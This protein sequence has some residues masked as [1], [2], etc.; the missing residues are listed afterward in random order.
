[1]NAAELKEYLGSEP[2]REDWRLLA[3]ELG[4]EL[5]RAERQRVAETRAALG[6]WSESQGW[7]Q[8]YRAALLDMLEGLDTALAEQE[9][10]EAA[11]SLA[12]SRGWRRLLP[13]L[14]ARS[15]KPSELAT[16]CDMDLA[17]V[18][19]LLSE[20]REAGLAETAPGLDAR[21]RPHRL[22]LRGQRLWTR[23]EAQE[24]PRSRRGRRAGR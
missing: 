7:E 24:A 18:S 15:M 14:A 12:V 9:D 11:E 16:R 5:S 13:E 17:Q 23:L 1:M 19:R 21:T 22:T 10:E 20:L 2:S 8:G 6:E 4:G 3:L